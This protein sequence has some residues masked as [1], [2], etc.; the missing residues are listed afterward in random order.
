MPVKP[1]PQTTTVLRA[2]LSVVS[3]ML[4]V[5]LQYAGALKL[6]EIEGMLGAGH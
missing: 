2:S 4:Q 6:V 5:L 1:P 3:Q